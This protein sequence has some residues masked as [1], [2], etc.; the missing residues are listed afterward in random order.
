MIKQEINQIY[1]GR[2]RIK[3]RV[4][5]YFYEAMLPV[6]RKLAKDKYGKPSASLFAFM[7]VDKELKANGKDFSK[8]LKKK[9]K[10]VCITSNV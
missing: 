10:Q 2:N 8:M 7:C 1:L 9:R 3:K 4:N 5:D 6:M